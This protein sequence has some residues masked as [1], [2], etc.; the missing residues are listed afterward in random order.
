[1]C[2]PKIHITMLFGI[3][4]IG[5][6]L[7]IYGLGAKS[8][9][10]DEAVTASYLDFSPIA[11]VH[12][13]AEVR[14]VHPPLYFVFIRCWTALAGNS[15]IALRGPSVVFGLATILGVYALIRELSCFPRSLPVT[16]PASTALLAALLVAL[17]PMQIELSRTARGYTMATA[18]L[19]YGGWALVR[20]L[21]DR[22]RYGSWT[23]AALLAAAACYTHYMT[24]LSVAANGL[25]AIV[26]IAWRWT[27]ACNA[28]RFPSEGAESLESDLRG[29]LFALGL[30][31]AVYLIPW[32][33]KLL[34]QSETVR[35][36][37]VWPITKERAL[38]QVRHAVY[39]S[40]DVQWTTDPFSLWI[41]TILLGSL[42]TYL[43]C[44]GGWRRWYLV[45]AGLLPPLVLAVYSLRTD[46]SIFH[47]RYL[48]FAQLAWLGGT[49]VVVSDIPIREIRAFFMVELAALSACACYDNWFLINTSAQ[50]GMRAATRFILDHRTTGEPIV[51]QTPY[52]FF[53]LKYY[54][55]GTDRPLLCVHVLRRQVQYGS[56]QLHDEELV[57]PEQLALVDQSGIWLVTSD[58]YN[59]SLIVT[60]PIPD[61]WERVGSWS[62]DQ[63][64]WLERPIQVVHYRI[65]RNTS[66]PPRSTHRVSY[67]GQI[68]PLQ[69]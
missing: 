64:R 37:I 14:A 67:E 20:A 9:W 19:S 39:S 43:A 55:R 11:I 12:R 10:F 59:P 40:Y 69:M 66:R 15:E 18:F 57:T 6:V 3:L 63:D 46:H 28:R 4:V 49:A 33:P 21:Q 30:F 53:G 54:A 42:F 26:F 68:S 44:R 41:V 61:R 24:V 23:A 13:C 38:D 65:R 56:E 5:T 29:P 2:I 52:V 60:P 8:I 58:S 31:T 7:R 45:A 34:P 17:S 1:M 27:S 62:F 32:F 16:P 35:H 50:P 36:S 47:A 51:A 22:R 25:F 48:C